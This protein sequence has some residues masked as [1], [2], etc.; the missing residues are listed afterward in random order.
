MSNTVPPQNELELLSW[1]KNV[2]D[3]LTASG[4]AFGI[5][6][7][8]AS[9]FAASYVKFADLMAKMDNPDLRTPKVKTDKDTQKRHLTNA[10]R[11]V[12]RAVKAH[13]GITDSQLTDLRIPIPDRERT[14][15][16]PPDESPN[17][18]VSEVLGR[19]V[20]LEL[21]DEEGKRRKPKGVK[22]AN[23]YTF[24]G[25]SP[26]DDLD[27]WKFEGGTTR[28]KVTH[29]FPQTVQPG[30]KVWFVAIYFNPRM[31]TGYACDP[32]S[33]YTTGGA[34]SRAA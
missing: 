26:P 22:G 1:S 14:P 30:T 13:F 27:A 28:T 19:H 7:E 20:T 3:K 8:T 24:V 9:S 12:I 17:L 16:D 31:Q 6:P 15:I 10:C 4:D 5:G 21:R 29:T 33:T 34:M 2:S 23:L 11:G 25:D 18:I 32:V